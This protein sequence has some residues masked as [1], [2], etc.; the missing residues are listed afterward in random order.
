MKKICFVFLSAMIIQL[1]VFPQIALGARCSFV[2]NDFFSDNVLLYRD[3][4]GTQRG[5]NWNGRG[6]SLEDDHIKIA[7][8]SNAFLAGDARFAMPGTVQFELDVIPTATTCNANV[9]LRLVNQDGAVS[10]QSGTFRDVSI[11]GFNN[12][13]ELL[14][15]AAWNGTAITAGSYTANTPYQFKVTLDWIKGSY[16]VTLVSGRLNDEEKE[17]EVLGGAA[18]A[19]DV[20]SFVGFLFYN[21][22]SD[23]Y[24]VDHVK[25]TPLPSEGVTCDQLSGNDAGSYS[26]ELDATTFDIN[27]NQFIDVSA[28]T[29]LVV[30]KRAV[31]NA[32]FSVLNEGSD[33]TLTWG[34]ESNDGLTGNPASVMAWKAKPTITLA[35]A[36]AEGDEY[37][38]D[39]SV[40]YDAYGR[41]FSNAKMNFIFG[42]PQDIGTQVEAVQKDIETIV[43]NANEGVDFSA[44]TGDLTLP[45]IGPDDTLITWLS[46]SDDT[47]LTTD[48]TVYRPS[49]DEDTN[50]DKTVTLSGTVSKLGISLPI[51][52][53]VTVKMLDLSEDLPG[54]DIRNIKLID[55]ITTN[56][57]RIELPQQGE[58]GTKFSW[59][60]SNASAIDAYGV[61]HFSSTPQ[62][63]VLTVKAVREDGSEISV[64]PRIFSF[65][66]PAKVTQSS[67]Q[68]STHSSPQKSSGGSRG[69]VYVSTPTPT[70]TPTPAPTPTAGT[71]PNEEDTAVFSDIQSADLAWAIESINYL[72]ENDIISGDGDQRFRPNEHIKREEFVKMLV[73]AFQLEAEAAPNPFDDVSDTQW[74]APYIAV[75]AKRGIVYGDGT[76]FGVGQDITRQ[77]IAVMI[78][79]A[80][81]VT[82]AA[83]SGTLSMEFDDEAGIADYAKEAMM[84]LVSVG[85]IKGYEDQTIRAENPATRAETAKIIYTVLETIGLQQVD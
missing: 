20:F 13:G 51:E 56:T 16:E 48:G 82:N 78:L 49:Y 25:V 45:L 84:K 14:I 36:G 59:S 8:N 70:S 71:A 33:Y 5:A 24:Y 35:E 54:Q 68:N 77:D 27:V 17:N 31:G 26:A 46:S 2:T 42:E 50:N 32:E 40:A 10:A 62:S 61:V 67:T 34:I 80:A 6:A 72:A 58:N 55:V 73:T 7:A 12:Q 4:T 57:T 37:E 83:L 19:S 39:F 52:I 28:G 60:T 53:T 43:K 3:G 29:P 66:V 23:V 81:D 79:R 47:V 21:N 30:R 75:A 63:V 44:V 38:F 18:F 9:Y 85:A 11:I 64:K 69:V 65:T 15:N 1:F 41:T 22:S 74:Y 76:N